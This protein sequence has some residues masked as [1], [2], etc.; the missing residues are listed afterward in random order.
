[1]IGVSLG[2]IYFLEITAIFSLCLVKHVSIKI[3]LTPGEFDD[4][5][6]WPFRGI[7]LLDQC[8]DSSYI[9]HQ[10]WFTTLDNLY[11]KEKPV[12][13]ENE[14]GAQH[15]GDGVD[16]FITHMDLKENAGFLADTEF[17]KN[18]SLVDV[19]YQHH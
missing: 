4:L 10:V 1:M 14:D 7:H 17:L 18:N 12:M 3:A 2:L 15:V 5:L 11:V 16:R 9:T 13:D 19:F 8:R 6:C